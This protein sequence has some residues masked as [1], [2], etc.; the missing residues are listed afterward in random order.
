MT[1]DVFGWRCISFSVMHWHHAG[2][3]LVE[4]YLRGHL[5]YTLVLVV[6]VYVVIA[7]SEIW[8]VVD[9]TVTR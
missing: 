3:F 4:W 5:L 6:V 1:G 9:V 8:R 2:K 7:L